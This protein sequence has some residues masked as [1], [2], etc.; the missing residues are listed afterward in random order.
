MIWHDHG[1]TFHLLGPLVDL[2][3]LYALITA[4]WKRKWWSAVMWPK[5]DRNLSWKETL[6]NGELELIQKFR[7]AKFPEDTEK[8][9]RFNIIA[10]EV[11]V[12]GL[13]RCGWSHSQLSRGPLIEA[14]SRHIDG[15]KLTQGHVQPK[16]DLECE[17]SQVSFL[18]ICCDAK[19]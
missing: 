17:T 4:I 13:T 5:T 14:L 10:A 3:T 1:I 19:L 18:K 9:R 16:G 7:E 6:K 11:I 12:A 2:K 15:D 8:S